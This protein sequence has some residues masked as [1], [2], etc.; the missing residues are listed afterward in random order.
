MS[1][2]AEKTLFQ[3][4]IDKEIP[5]EILFQDELC[6]V[7]KD[8]SPKAPTHVLIIPIKPIARLDQ[9]DKEDEQ[10]LGHLLLIAKNQAKALG[11]V[12]GFRVIINN[13]RDAGEAIPHLHV[14]LLGGRS[15]HWPPG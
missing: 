13:G 9:A 2:S 8:I 10:L 7:I 4:I 14:H 5:G 3:K 11:L 12:N 1:K 15:M 6:V